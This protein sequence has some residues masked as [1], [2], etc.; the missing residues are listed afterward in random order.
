M[1]TA[2][3]PVVN[4]VDTEALHNAIRAIAED[5]ARGQTRWQ[6]TTRWQGGTRSDTSVRCYQIGGQTVEKDFN[7]PIDEPQ[8]LCGTNRYANPQEYL[9]AAMNA[10]ITVGYVTACAMKGIELEELWIDTEGDIDLRGFLG[11]DPDV[12]PGYDEIRY[13]VHIKA[14]N[15]DVDELNE[16]HQIVS[17]L[18]PN[19]FNVAN[20]IRLD[21]R[22]VVE[23][24]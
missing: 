13:T 6:V 2:T 3:R 12:K 22:L 16:V 23:T 7:I 14:K 18:S 11:I 10:C 15:A 5:P 24:P 19:R 17:A 9:M 20:A 8:E 4:G 21:S 1:Q